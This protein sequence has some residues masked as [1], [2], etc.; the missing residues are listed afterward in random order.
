MKRIGRNKIRKPVSCLITG[1]TPFGQLKK[2]PSQLIVESM[3]AAVPLAT[4]A[5][6]DSGSIN[7]ETLVLP[8]CC[9][10]SWQKLKRRLDR[11]EPTVLIMLGVAE[12]RPRVSLERFAVNIRDY[13]LADNNGHRPVGKPV[14]QGGPSAYE[15][16]VNLLQLQKQLK[17]GGFD[18]D[19]SNHAGTFVCNDLFYSAL[20]RQETAGKPLFVQF[21]HVP[22]W[23]SGGDETEQIRELVK[24]VIEIARLC[25][26]FS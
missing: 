22:G 2:N 21:V 7:V 25:A 26:D 20:H 13:S 24:T 15:S 14:R 12:G 5:D 9:R 1:F 11:T 3:P 4:N 17:E 8:T 6:G 19:I 16:R 23:Q 10:S 18:C